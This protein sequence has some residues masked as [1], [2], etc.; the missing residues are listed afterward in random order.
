MT[1]Y[2]Y[3]FSLENDIEYPWQ[4]YDVGHDNVT[5]G[6]E[7]NGNGV[8]TCVTETTTTNVPPPLSNTNQN[9]PF[10]VEFM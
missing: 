8:E 3:K 1:Q 4:R 7:L 10:K 6:E 2:T 5:V 9:V